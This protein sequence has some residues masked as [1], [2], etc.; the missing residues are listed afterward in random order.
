MKKRIEINVAL[1]VFSKDEWTEMDAKLL[2]EAEKILENAHAPYS[3]FLV[4][5]A[6]LLENG[7][8][9][10]ANNQENV[11]FPVGVCAERA[12][13]S[14]AMANNPDI[15]PVKLAIVA[16][17]REGME[18]ATVTPCGLCRQTINEYEYKFGRSIEI[19]MLGPDDEM[20][21]ASGIDQLLPFRF[22]DLND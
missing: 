9:F 13:L 4:G 22:S 21:R 2:S 16:K 8:I 3:N 10:S 11:S 15:A 6:L 17:R 1:E 7:Q 20:F 5:A 19:L 14:Y 18:L 12:V